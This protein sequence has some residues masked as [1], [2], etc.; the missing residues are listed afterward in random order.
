ME[1]T[2]LE[3]FVMVVE[4]GSFS[5]AA[6]RVYRTQP[7]VSIAIRRLEQEIGA[8]LFDRSQKTPTL[9]DAGQIVY[10]Y[11]QRILSLRDQAQDVVSE[12]R[13]LQQGRVRI[14]ANESTSLYL[15]PHIILEYRARHPNVKVKIFRHVSERLPREVLDRNVDF[16]LL[17]Y[18]PVD[19]D[20]ES[21]P[22]LQDELVLIMNPDHPLAECESVKIKDLGQAVL[23]WRIML[24][25]ASPQ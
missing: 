9:T 22:I 18:E 3:F 24:K 5:K 20:L 1:L 14:G 19:N 21:F 16:A 6:V 25:T 11:A 7:A 10:D 12:L 17:A 8:P 13:S 23:P 4:E 2:Q 15:L